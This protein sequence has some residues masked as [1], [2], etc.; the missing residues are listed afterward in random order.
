MLNKIYQ[1]LTVLLLLL[2]GCATTRIQSVQKSPDF[3]SAH[4]RKV[5]IV[6]VTSTP[7]LRKQV[8][9]EFVKQWKERGVDV[10]ASESVLPLTVTLDKAGIG[11]FAKTQ[12]FDSVLVTRLVKREKIEPQIVRTKGETAPPPADD[13]NLTQYMGA[14]VA[15]PEYG[16]DFEVAIVSANLYDVPTEMRL[17]SGTT[18]TLLTDDVPKRV[19]AFT[20]VI[21]KTIYT[22]S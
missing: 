3:N 9:W 1:P 4:I 20:Q 12:G 17:W 10:V 2:N 19:R 13:S 7:G 18:Q 11:A 14:V 6:A 16:M 5:L 22:P 21:L 8:E 15:S